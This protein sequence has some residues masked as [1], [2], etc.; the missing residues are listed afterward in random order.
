MSW[1][2]TSFFLIFGGVHLYAFIKWR[3]ALNPGIIATIITALL[4]VLMVA[5]PVLVRLAERGGHTSLARCLAY[6]GYSWMGIIFLFFSASLTVDFLKL[7]FSLTARF[8]RNPA[9]FPVSPFASFI[10]PLMIAFISAGYGFFEGNHIV[11]EHITVMSEKISMENSP[12]KIVQISDLHLGLIEREGRLKKV[13]DIIMKEKPDL[14]VSTGDLVD[15]QM[16]DME[17]LALLFR[18]VSPRFGMYAVTGNHE[19]YAGLPQS[20]EFTEKCGFT[21][22]RG[23][24]IEGIINVAGI[25]DPA[26]RYYDLDPGKEEGEILSTLP[27]DRF[28]LLL[29]HRPLI[30]HE[31]GRKADLQLSGH[32][33][34]G[35]IF[36]FRILTKVYY[37]RDSGLYRDDDGTQMYVSRGTGT[38]GPPMRILSPPEITVITL[39]HKGD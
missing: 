9:H 3:S 8:L 5:A 15:G 20:I 13:V 28:T 4:M 24:G 6:I 30:N 37:P 19:F 35:Q 7:V 2:L 1:F 21:L 38:W 17:S 34:K 26:G 33:H 39:V 22:L 23:K 25:D 14:L 29:K 27:G 12:I 10:I 36:P 11:T 32:T 18:K 31:P 16:Y